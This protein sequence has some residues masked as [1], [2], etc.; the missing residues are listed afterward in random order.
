M[1]EKVQQKI[2]VHKSPK[3]YFL[4]V[5]KYQL[6]LCDS[7]KNNWYPG[8]ILVN[9]FDPVYCSANSIAWV[10]PITFLKEII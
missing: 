1:K 2:C 8:Q 4:H 9:I 5:T 3:T 10:D 7:L 6:K